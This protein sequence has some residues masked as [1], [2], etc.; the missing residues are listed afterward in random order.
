M[1]SSLDRFEPHAMRS[2][3][4]SAHLLLKPDSTKMDVVEEDSTADSANAPIQQDAPPTKEESPKA[5]PAEDDSAT[6][7]DDDD[8]EEENK[9][10]PAKTKKN[11]QPVNPL[12]SVDEPP[13]KKLKITIKAVPADGSG[14]DS[15]GGKAPT[16]N[17]KK[18]GPPVRQPVRRGG[19][20]W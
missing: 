9:H 18:K 3:F 10:L 4:Y 1:G 13:L 7:P 8:D 12:S 15:E 11:S 19:K 6:E 16:T 5:E 14:S 17:P 20:K 2:T